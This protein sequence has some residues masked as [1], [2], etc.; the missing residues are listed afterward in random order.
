MT[1][2]RRVRAALLLALSLWTSACFAYKDVGRLPESGDLPNDLRIYRYDGTVLDLASSRIAA[3]T[4]RGFRPRSSTPI[5]VPLAHVDS[6]QTRQLEKR[7]SLI[8]GG[9]AV[10]VLAVLFASHV[11][12]LGEPITPELQMP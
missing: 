2:S 7:S 5:L 12:S 8:V 3:D 4:I 6:L 1:L 11:S 9:L 10:A